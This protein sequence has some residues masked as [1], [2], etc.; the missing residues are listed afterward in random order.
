MR[1]WSMFPGEMSNDSSRLGVGSPP[2]PKISVVLV[3][4]SAPARTM[5]ARLLAP[6]LHIRIAGQAE[7]GAEGLALASR[8][9]P[10]LVITDLQMPGLNGLQLVE[11]LRRD[12]PRMHSLITS[13]YDSATCHAASLRHGADAFIG[14]RRLHEEFPGLLERLFPDAAQPA[15][16]T[17]QE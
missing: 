17:C 3:D 2:D 5:L 8:L 9:Q 12:Y 10:D 13:V 15:T 7:N 16:G 1:S 14:K 4:D 11:L 6:Y